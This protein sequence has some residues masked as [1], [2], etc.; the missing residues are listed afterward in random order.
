[1]KVRVYAIVCWWYDGAV[2]ALA[3]AI[4]SFVPTSPKNQVSLCREGFA[5]YLLYLVVFM[6]ERLWTHLFSI[7]NISSS[8]FYSIIHLIFLY[9]P[10]QI[11]L[12]YNMF[13]TSIMLNCFCIY[14][15]QPFLVI[16]WDFIFFFLQVLT[17]GS[18]Y[19]FD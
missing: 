6:L 12:M 4:S 1:M 11:T 9:L 10:T 19:I 2:E 5:I 8:F 18:N 7:Q 3:L 14:Q 13:L 17:F 16:F 15:F